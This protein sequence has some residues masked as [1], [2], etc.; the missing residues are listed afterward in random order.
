MNTLINLNN[1]NSELNLFHIKSE[2][3]NKYGKIIENHNFEKIHDYLQNNTKIPHQGNI[4]VPND[5]NLALL[6]K[7]NIE[8]KNIFGDMEIQ[9]GYCNGKNSFL[10][11]LEY[12][13]CSEINYSVTDLVL[14][15]GKLQDIRNNYYDVKNIEA[16]FIPAKTSF[17]IYQTTLHYSPCKTNNE[18]FKMLVVLLKG[19]NTILENDINIIEEEDK[20]LFMKNK[21]LI[22]HSEN[23]KAVQQGAFVGLIGKN[24]NIHY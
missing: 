18:G 17:E 6:F 13:K 19:T 12:H 5:D 22:S 4:Y 9:V 8:K 2:N 15:L 23:K 21:W 24:L 1:K 16:F 10:N 20:L 3:F 7:E 11:A 14:L